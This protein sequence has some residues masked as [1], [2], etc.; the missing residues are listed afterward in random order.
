MCCRE[1]G[2]SSV[3]PGTTAALNGWHHPPSH[4]A[5]PPQFSQY[6][7]MSHPQ[8]MHYMHGVVAPDAWNTTQPHGG[9]HLLQENGIPV[10][11]DQVDEYSEDETQTRSRPEASARMSEIDR[12]LAGTSMQSATDSDSSPSG[13]SMSSDDASSE[14]GRSLEP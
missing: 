2:V 11:P 7:H 3:Q 8:Q 12:S 13:Y 1:S 4:M 10:Y 5:Y 6:Q 14:S 9:L